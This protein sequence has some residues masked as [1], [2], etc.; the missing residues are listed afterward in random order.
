MHRKPTGGINK[1][2]KHSITRSG[3][4]EGYARSDPT[5]GDA[6]QVITPKQDLMGVRCNHITT[7]KGVKLG[8][9]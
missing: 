9:A 8:K 2:G 6:Y 3:K 4:R 5:S 1:H 7:A